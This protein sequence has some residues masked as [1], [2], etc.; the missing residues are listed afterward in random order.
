MQ[1]AAISARVTDVH[2]NRFDSLGPDGL[3]MLVS[4]QLTGTYAVGD[5]VYHDGQKVCQLLERNSAIGRGAAGETGGH[6]LI[7][8]NVDTLAVVT[9]CNDDF[10]P[11]ML[12]PY[13][14][15]CSV[16]SALCSVVLTKADLTPDASGF[17]VTR[18]SYSPW[19]SR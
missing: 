18:K 7:V 17:A 3:L 4:S 19:S 5:W 13:R 8:S 1:P 9:I 2:R 10:N 11:T 12:D 16:G 15:L 6:Q 14:A